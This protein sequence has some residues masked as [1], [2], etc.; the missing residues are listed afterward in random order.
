MSL[1]ACRLT[2]VACG[3]LRSPFESAFLDIQEGGRFFQCFSNAGLL[4]RR[5]SVRSYK[6]ASNLIARATIH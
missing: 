1:D 2:L 3:S 4:Y 5:I 6:A